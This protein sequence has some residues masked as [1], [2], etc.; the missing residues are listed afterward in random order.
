MASIFTDV[1]VKQV[2]EVRTVALLLHHSSPQSRKAAWSIA[3]GNT[4]IGNAVIRAF[5]KPWHFSISL[6]ASRIQGR[7]GSNNKTP[8]LHFSATKRNRTIEDGDKDDAPDM[9]YMKRSTFIG[10]SS[11]HPIGPSF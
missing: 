9:M 5:L 6:T 2:S 10:F 4:M 1:S 8:H 11:I 3:A 7:Q